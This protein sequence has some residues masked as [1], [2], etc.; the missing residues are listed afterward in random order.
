VKNKLQFR[1]L[2]FIS[3]LDE[4]LKKLINLIEYTTCMRCLDMT[5]KPEFG[6][7]PVRTVWRMRNI[8]GG[9]LSKL[10]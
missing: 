5:E 9:I 7:C 1:G 8:S 10:F 3:K 4:C 6:W 2:N